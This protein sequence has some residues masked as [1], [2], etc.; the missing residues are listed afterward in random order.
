VPLRDF[1]RALS[2]LVLDARLRTVVL[3]KGAKALAAYNL[4]FL[5]QQRLADMSQ[6]RGLALLCTLARGNR[7]APIVDVF[8]LT[9]E[10]LKG[11]LRELLDELWSTHRSSN[12]QLAGEEE[13]FAGLLK[14][15]IGRREHLHPYA[16]E[17]FCYEYECFKVARLVRY[18]SAEELSRLHPEH[19]R[20]AYFRHDP[21]ILLPALEKLQT[22]PPDLP[23]GDYRVRITLRHDA[24]DVELDYDGASGL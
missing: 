12:Y 6:Q 19:V 8:P 15:K 21:R 23:E 11:E 20:F 1:Q 22:P 3:E 2:D 24:L 7:F 5:E 17:V 18:L 16:K 10:L 14:N 4:T 9:C 13:A